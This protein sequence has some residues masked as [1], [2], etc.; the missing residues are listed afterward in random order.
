MTNIRIR[1]ATATAWAMIPMAA[2]AGMPR[3]GCVCSNGTIKLFCQFRLDSKQSAPGKCGS[4]CCGQKVTDD[5]IDCCAVCSIRGKSGTPEIASKSCCNPILALPS[6]P[7]QKV[8]APLGHFPADVIATASAGTLLR[9]AFITVTA[10]LN[11]GPPLDR[12]VV[13]RSLLI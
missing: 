13:F 10:E 6:V 9:S 1:L 7:T 4:D 3:A 8:S 11:T 2:W 5:E 12:V